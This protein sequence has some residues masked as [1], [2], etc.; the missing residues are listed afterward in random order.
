MPKRRRAA[1]FALALTGAVLAMSSAAGARA[2]DPSSNFWVSPSCGTTT[3]CLA[4]AIT[5]LN[6]ARARMGEPSYRLPA[7]FS[8][9][10]ADKQAFVLT[11]LDRTLY[12]LPPIAGLTG[13]LDQAAAT[14]VR[15]NTD[16]SISAPGI[17]TVTGNWGG[18][19]RN[20]PFAYEAWMYDDGPGGANLDCT[21]LN[22]SGCWAHRHNVLWSF[23][24]HGPL[25]MGAAAGADSR[26]TGGYALVI[27]QGDRSYHPD[28]LYTWSRAL[29]AGAGPGAGA[30]AGA[31]G[32]PRSEPS[33]ASAARVR[34]RI[35]RLRVGRHAL[36]FRVSA[37]PGVR[38]ACSLS[39]APRRRSAA[40]RPCGPEVAYRH[41]R[42]GAYRLRV[43]A[44]GSVVARSLR[45]RAR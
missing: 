1:S 29:P 12:G 2:P 20:L 38:V 22:P 23:S 37:P 32:A 31:G 9:L 3:S 8:Q 28:Y 18:G 26:G 5:V 10:G 24:G 36:R 21:A 17:T 7:N 6:Q 16:P 15:L 19:Y 39:Y 40:F 27:V 14:A 45:I 35:S 42:S 34:V 41:L 11:N 13:Q 44:G 43:R 4:A 25:A 30:G 33:S